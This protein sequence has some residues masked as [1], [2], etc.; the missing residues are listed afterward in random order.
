MNAREIIEQETE[1]SRDSFE[2]NP[3]PD[4]LD[5][6]WYR[7][8]MMDRDFNPPRSPN[9]A[10]R[11]GIPWY[12]PGGKLRRGPKIHVD[13]DVRAAGPTTT[14]AD[15]K[16]SAAQCRTRN[17]KRKSYGYKDTYSMRERGWPTAIRNPDG[18]LKKPRIPKP[19]ENWEI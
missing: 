10:R 6:D 14:G 5:P 19:P 17:D 9:E 11:R 1:D 2:G 18:S 8:H 12:M 15:F 4:A 13:L 3:R 16:K 7:W